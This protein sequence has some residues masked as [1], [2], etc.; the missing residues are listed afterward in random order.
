MGPVLG[1]L[2]ELA[3]QEFALP[4]AVRAEYAEA[5]PVGMRKPKPKLLGCKVGEAM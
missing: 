1:G 3:P 5:T 4:R 2:A